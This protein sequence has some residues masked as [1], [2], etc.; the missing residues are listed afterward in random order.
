MYKF[1]Y[2]NETDNEFNNITNNVRAI[3]FDIS[4]YGKYNH[5]ITYDQPVTTSKA[6]RDAEEYL[7]QPLTDKEYQRLKDDLFV[8]SRPHS[9]GGCLGD[10]KIIEYLSIYDGI[11]TLS[12]GS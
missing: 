1:S 5:T 12:V 9:R 4:R 10:C 2:Y 7:S 3:I 11:L 6:I 8:T